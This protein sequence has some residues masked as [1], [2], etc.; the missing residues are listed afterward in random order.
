MESEMKGICLASTAA[1]ALLSM[2]SLAAAH[3]TVSATTDLNVRSGP[4]PQFDVVG[5]IDATEEADLL[6]CLEES[7]WCKVSHDGTE[8][9]SYSDYLAASFD[10]TE[11]IV[12]LTQRPPESVPVAVHEFTEVPQVSTTRTT[13]TTTM[14]DDEAD[15]GE[16]GAL[17]GA[18][19]G[20][21]AGA[22]I[23]GPIGAAV[24]GVA[25]AVAGGTMEDAIDPPK[26]VVTYVE[27]NRAEPVYLEGEVVRGAGIPE[28]VELRPIPDYEYRYVYV[29]RQPVL[30][31]PES[32]RIVYVIR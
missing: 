16:G 13:T 14:T 15:D 8:G 9:W 18:A 30:V 25:G 11:E 6:G 24:G 4:G 31:E 21:V 19:T 10:G 17:A 32:R 20:A 5:V 2:T 29:N 23:G 27:E 28:T 1:A 7:K 22:L 12:V 3:T 26:E